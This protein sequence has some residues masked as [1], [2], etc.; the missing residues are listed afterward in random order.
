M[1]AEKVQATVNDLVEKGKISDD[2]GKKIV[3]EFFETTDDKKEEIESKF[4][5]A[6]DSFAKKFEFAKKS[7]LKEL[8]TRIEELE[9]ELARMKEGEGDSK[10]VTTKKVKKAEDEAPAQESH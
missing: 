10:K 2:E 9:A 6:F 4:K 8:E 5:T 3:D 1:A 7:E